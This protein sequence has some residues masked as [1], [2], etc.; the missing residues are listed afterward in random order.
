MQTTSMRAQPMAASPGPVRSPGAMPIVGD[1]CRSYEVP[2]EL[3]RLEA[4]QSGNR[5]LL[6]QLANRLSPTL[7]SKPSVVGPLKEECSPAC[8]LATRLRGISDR[9]YQDGMVLTQLL[10]DLEV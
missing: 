7:A 3:D 1:P 10:A 5:N 2:V 6:E 8:A 4:M 9:L